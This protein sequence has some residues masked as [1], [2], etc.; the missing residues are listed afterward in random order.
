MD[1]ACEE[2]GQEYCECGEYVDVTYF[3]G[4][5]ICNHDQEDHGWAGCYV[6]GCPCDAHI[7]E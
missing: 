2:C 1:Q 7:E 5:C 6:N 3:V 4:P